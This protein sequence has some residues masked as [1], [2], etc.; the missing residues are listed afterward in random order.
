MAT[1]SLAEDT[2]LGRRVAL[3][4]LPAAGDP[5]G[6]LRLRREALVGASLNHPNLVSVYDAVIEDDD[7]VVVMEYVPGETLADVFRSRGPLAPEGALRILHGVAAALD[8][9][10]ERGIVHRDVK[11]ANVLLGPEGQVKL[12]DL[13]VA[14]VV[15]RT[16]ITSAGMIVGSYSY[17]PPE[18]LEGSSP[19]PA[20]DVY[21]LAAVA[22]EALAGER[23]RPET[24]PVALAHALATQPPPDLARA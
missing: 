24:N 9:I 8:V 4:R 13:G 23:A 15:D 12:A 2:V 20:M 14:D 7:V 18:Q 22:Y 17:M 5:R 19:T 10:H 6:M 16:R 3:K 1:V 21:A 11:P